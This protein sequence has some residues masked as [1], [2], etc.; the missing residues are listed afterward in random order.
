VLAQCLN[1]ASTAVLRATVAQ[2]DMPPT[3]EQEQLQRAEEAARQ[4]SNL[5]QVASVTQLLQHP[6]PAAM[7]EQQQ[8]LLQ[9]YAYTLITVMSELSP[10]NG[11]TD[12]AEQVRCLQQRATD[13]VQQPASA[14]AWCQELHRS[15]TLVHQIDDMC[16][17]LHQASQ[18]NALFRR[19]CPCWWWCVY[20]C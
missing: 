14:T 9:H 6:P 10:V 18:N 1:F 5:I 4:L 11:A 8:D 2:Y 17:V 15:H 12:P 19:T 20:R 16:G 3:T 13:A 7:S